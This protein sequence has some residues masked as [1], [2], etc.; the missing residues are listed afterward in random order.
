MSQ[1]SQVI[2]VY[3]KLL[4][5]GKDWPQGY[6]Y[7]RDRCKRAFNKNKHVV[8]EKQINAMIERAEFVVKEIEAL[9]KL[10]KYRTLKKRYYE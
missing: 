5:L 6:H 9:Y 10:K 7:F 8:D 2:N 3:K 4:Y 1:R